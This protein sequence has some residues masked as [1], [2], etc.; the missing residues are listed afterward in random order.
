MQNEK[1]SE[2][3]STRL[4]SHYALED[5]KCLSATSSQPLKLNSELKILFMSMGV[6]QRE[7]EKLF[8]QVKKINH[9]KAIKNFSSCQC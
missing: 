9:S 7:E 4:L 1:F 3:F 8:G 6:V 5:V 2:F